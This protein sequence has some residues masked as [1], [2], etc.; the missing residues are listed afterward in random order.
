M[1]KEGQFQKEINKSNLSFKEQK[2]DNTK[3]DIDKHMHVFLCIHV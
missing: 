3:T 1:R 2:R